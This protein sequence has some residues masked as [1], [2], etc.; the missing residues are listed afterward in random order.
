[1]LLRTMPR[2]YADRE[3]IEREFSEHFGKR[4]TFLKDWS[5]EELRKA[6][7]ANQELDF[8]DDGW[9]GECIGMCGTMI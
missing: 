3:R 7:E 1:M 8:T 9:Q 2:V 4:C 5:L 6:E